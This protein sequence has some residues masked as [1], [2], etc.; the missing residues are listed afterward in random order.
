[1]KVVLLTDVSGLGE[2]GEIV[3]VAAGYARNYLLPRE[4]AE[5]ATAGRMKEVRRIKAAKAQRAQKA[6]AR[7]QKLAARFKDLVVRVEARG[8]EGGKLFGS[9]G[10]KD[11]AE[12]LAARADIRIDRKKIE[13]GETIKA[14]GVY[15]ALARLHPGVTADFKV[16]VVDRDA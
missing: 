8:G 13:L 2:R 4:L 15:P 9:V 12:A 5:E 16:E 11:V 10:N 1:M 7:A 6:K 14:L 3:E